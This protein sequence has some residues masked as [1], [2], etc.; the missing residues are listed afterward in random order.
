MDR[1]HG[2]DDASHAV[3][4]CEDGTAGLGAVGGREGDAELVPVGRLIGQFPAGL[5]DDEVVL[6]AA[7]MFIRAAVCGGGERIAQDP[8]PF[9]VGE[10]PSVQLELDVVALDGCIE[11]GGEFR[12]MVQEFRGDALEVL[13]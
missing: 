1:V 6:P 2:L 12:L 9:G 8:Q 10:S 7:V 13:R 11:P 3:D 5:G 4:G